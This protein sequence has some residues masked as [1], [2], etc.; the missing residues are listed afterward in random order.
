[1]KIFICLVVI[2]LLNQSVFAQTIQNRDNNYLI[3]YTEVQKIDTQ[4]LA[5]MS[6]SQLS[7]VK[8]LARGN[9]AF[10][11]TNGTFSKYEAAPIITKRNTKA[12]AD[13][14]NTIIENF[15]PKMPL[16]AWYKFLNNDSAYLL[17][18]NTG[19]KLLV[20]K[21]NDFKWK[22]LPDTL[23]IGNLVTRLAVSKD[24]DTA[25]YADNYPI[26]DGPR[27]YWGLPGL[28]VKLETKYMIYQLKSITKDAESLITV[29]PKD[30]EIITWS[31]YLALIEARNNSKEFGGIHSGKTTSKNGNSITTTSIEVKRTN[32]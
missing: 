1:M 25:Y 12:K 18:N 14:A 4:N 10:L 22:L 3:E 15:D 20:S 8:Q 28:I 13:G 32:L 26:F 30:L 29:I 6:A 21:Q 9:S 11:K 16:M 19:K 24:N 27:G 2:N 23:S 17:T 31:N 7:Y 5:C